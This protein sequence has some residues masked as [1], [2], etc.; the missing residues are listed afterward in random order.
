MRSIS[1]SIAI[2]LLCACARP[3]PAPPAPQMGPAGPPAAVTGA[4]VEV[5]TQRGD[6]LVVRS[7][8][9]TTPLGAGDECPSFSALTH[10]GRR[11]EVAA[12]TQPRALV[13]Y[14]YPR[15]ETPGCTREACSLRDAFHDITA[16]GADVIGVSTDTLAAHRAFAEH[17]RLPFGLISDPDGRLA[18]AFG[19]RVTDGVA[20]RITFLVGRSGH[21]GRVF[22]DVRVDLHG[23]DVIEALATLH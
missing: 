17:H 8:S 13:V 6:S 14:F 2:A 21:V 19:L 1:T 3:L 12:G 7:P 9:R 5:E 4:E 15:D 10:E 18:A 20:P 23:A 16:A 22:P 11:V